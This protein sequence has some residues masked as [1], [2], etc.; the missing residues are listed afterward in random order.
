LRSTIFQNQTVAAKASAINLDMTELATIP[1]SEGRYT[2]AG[3]LP[4]KGHHRGQN[5]SLQPIASWANSVSRIESR[6]LCS[7]YA[8]I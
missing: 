2:I 3:Q 6:N 1:D 8:T 5:V 4:G 7:S